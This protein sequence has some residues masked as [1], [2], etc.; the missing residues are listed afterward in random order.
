MPNA[1]VLRQAELPGIEAL[2][3]KAQLRWTGQVLRLDDD[4]LPNQIF[5][6]LAPGTRTH[7]GQLKRYK[8]SL[9]SSLKVCSSL[10]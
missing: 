6:E 5:S 9:K 2:I 4:R 3:M 8:D 10:R 7:G 1:E